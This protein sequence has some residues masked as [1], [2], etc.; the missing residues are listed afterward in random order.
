M[1][2]IE[3][4]VSTTSRGADTVSGLLMICGAKGTQII[5][6]GDVLDAAR[7]PGFG[8]IIDAELAAKMP[9]DVQVKAWY[10]SAEDAISARSAIERL[11]GGKEA[12]FGA[13]TVSSST[14]ADEDW[15]ENWKKYFKTARIGKR[16]VI[17]PVWEEY[18]PLTGDLIIHM[19]PGMAFGTGAH[20]TTQLCLDM[21]ERTYQ[22]G[23]A[24]DIGTGSGILSI[25]LAKLGGGPVLAV[26]I[27]PVAVKAAGE[28]IAKNG[29]ADT[30]T[31]VAGDLLDHAAGQYAYICANILSDVVISLSD[32]LRP[33]LA[34]GARF[35]A[36]GII[37][38]RAA[39]VLDVYK[40]TGYRLVER[41]E[42]GEWVALLFE[43][44][45][46]P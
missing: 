46:A 2:W 42:L 4:C 24:L 39:E 30:V 27:D 43:D 1:D 17:K 32:R 44:A 33:L 3:V 5:D 10:A 15:A 13:L 38:D 31:V 9:E 34:P 6:R 22:G 21:I 20:E 45:A 40:K 14:V 36:S 18:T 29:L 11:A 35:L 37:R 7:L 28:N 41:R 26:D 16:L 8:E 19:E 23:P 25:A 12:D